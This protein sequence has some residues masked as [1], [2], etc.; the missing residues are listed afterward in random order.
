MK[1]GYLTEFSQKELDFAAKA[2]FECLSLFI[3][4]STVENEKSDYWK[5]MVD[6]CRE[7]HIA[8]SALGDTSTTLIP[9]RQNGNA[10]TKLS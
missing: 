2:G 1:L 7:K 9:T 8:I 3:Q 6:A 5:Q 10:K 4:L